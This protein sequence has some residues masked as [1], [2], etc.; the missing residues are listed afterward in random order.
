MATSVALLANWMA[1]PRLPDGAID[2]LLP[3]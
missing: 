1:G 3:F 2:V